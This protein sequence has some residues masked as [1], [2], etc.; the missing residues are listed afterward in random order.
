[1]RSIRI[2]PP[3]IPA[4]PTPP[5]LPH[6]AYPRHPSLSLDGPRYGYLHAAAG[7]P[8][9]PNRILLILPPSSPSSSSSRLMVIQL[10]T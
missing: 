7:D 2:P 6:P 3:R 5:L 1:M 10:S 9:G 8:A 4:P